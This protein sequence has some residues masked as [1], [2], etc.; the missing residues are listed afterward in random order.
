MNAIHYYS[1]LYMHYTVN[2]K[3]AIGYS[4][5]FYKNDIMLHKHTKNLK[6][7]LG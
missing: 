5:N 3:V 7:L 2:I 1:K 6:F 4:I